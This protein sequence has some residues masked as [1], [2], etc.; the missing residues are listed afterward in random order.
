MSQIKKLENYLN[1]QL[2]SY[3]ISGE[4]LSINDKDYYIVTDDSNVF[5]VVLPDDYPDDSIEEYIFEFCGRWYTQQFGEKLTLTEFKYIGVAIQK[6]PTKS[7]LAVHS[8]NELMNG[9]GTHKEWAKKAKFL[10][11]KALGICEKNSL[12]SVIS[13]QNECNANGIK[14]II[15]TELSIINNSGSIFTVKLYCINFQGWLNLLKFNTILNVDGKGQVEESFLT[16]NLEGLIVVTD[17]KTTDYSNALDC[18]DYFQ[19]DTVKYLDEEHDT[20]YLNNIERYIVGNK[21]KPISI[22]DAYCL[23][24]D[25]IYTRETLWDISKVYDYRTE[26]QYFKNKDQYASEL[27]ELFESGNNSWVK[28]FKEAIKNENKLVEEC[29]FTYDT[30]T[31]HLP[32]YIMTDEESSQFESNEKL[33]LHLVKEGFK[34]K[35]LKD[36]QKYIDRLKVEINVLKTGDVI[37]YFLSLHDIL[38]YAKSQG[39]LTGIGR[40]SAGGSLVAYLLGIIQVNPL[41][42]DLLF[43]RFLNLGRMGEW[44]DRPLYIFEDEEGKTLELPEGTLVKVLR[45]GKEVSVLVHDILE[46]DEILKY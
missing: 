36:P 28:L 37:D 15:G 7:F 14:P 13:F 8:G 27:I 42:F 11:V 43:S 24:K 12:S 20:W 46:G 35:N 33:F 4:T 30:N 41:D 10:G 26:N 22:Y 2:L 19:L 5:E 29:N 23:D 21:G 39:I 16:R 18:S 3:E 45:S 38:R 1:E 9:I 17:P 31:R 44:V 6:L 34:E 32:K 40:G 25:D